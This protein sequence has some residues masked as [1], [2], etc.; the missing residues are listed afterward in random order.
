LVLSTLPI[1]QRCLVRRDQLAARPIG[2]RHIVDRLSVCRA[3][4]V[5][6][7]PWEDLKKIT[8][9]TLIM[10]GSDDKIAPV[11]ISGN[12]TAEI[13]KDAKLVV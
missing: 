8:V 4:R 5:R 7:S 11:E 13:V 9:P 1:R 2:V 12:L 3:C 6:A 10:H